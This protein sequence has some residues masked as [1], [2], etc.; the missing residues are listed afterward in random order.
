MLHVFCDGMTEAVVHHNCTDRLFDMDG[1]GEI[2]RN[3]AES[4]VVS[5][6]GLEHRF[7]IRAGRHF[8]DG[9][10]VT[11]E[12]CAQSLRRCDAL[13][14]AMVEAKGHD[15]L[16]ISL[17]RQN[18]T[19]LNLLAGSPILN[20]VGVGS[21]PYR[22]VE[23]AGDELLLTAHH[24]HPGVGPGSF[25]HIRLKRLPAHFGNY[26]NL[27]EAGNC[28]LV[29]S[30]ALSW[31]TRNRARGKW[32]AHVFATGCTHV[33]C[34]KLGYRHT[35]FVK[36]VLQEVFR[37]NRAL[38]GE[39]HLREAIS[40][41]PKG[42][43]L[44]EPIRVKRCHDGPA[45]LR[46]AVT[47]G[48]IYP[49]LRQRISELAAA[50]ELTLIWV[51]VDAAELMQYQFCDG[52][53]VACA[54]DARDAL[55]AAR[56]WFSGKAS[57]IGNL[58]SDLERML[59]RC[60]NVVRPSDRSAFLRQFYFNLFAHGPALPLFFSPNALVYSLDVDA[61]DLDFYAGNLDFVKLTRGALPVAGVDD[62]SIDFKMLAH[63]LRKPFTLVKAVVNVLKATDDPVRLQNLLESFVPEVERVTQ[64]VESM[65]KDMM[66]REGPTTPRLSLHSMRRIAHESIRVSL[67]PDSR[68]EVELAFQHEHLVEVDRDKI[69]RVMVNLLS[70]ATQ[71]MA[72]DGKI[73]IRT[74]E[75]ATSA[76][77]FVEIKVGNTNSYIAP[78]D[79]KHLF[80]PWFTK[81]KE[82]GT[83]LGLAIA[84]R[85]VQAHGGTIA[86]R[87]SKDA[88]TEF[89]F[90][91]PASTVYEVPVASVRRAVAVND[92]VKVAVVEDNIFLLELWRE[93]FGDEV[94]LFSS[95]EEFFTA[96]ENPEFLP[97]LNAAITDYYFDEKSSATGADIARFLHLKAFGGKVL[98]A[99]DSIGIEEDLTLFHG[100]HAKEPPTRQTLIELLNQ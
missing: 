60:E 29:G 78:D 17:R 5:P 28:V 72:G 67:P 15:G 13:S 71:A 33:L 2:A 44:Y 40:F 1:K 100:R 86:V 18:P 14:D 69:D 61:V 45:T 54:I 7:Q 12:Q 39:A 43:S 57:L 3:L 62:P 16:R 6:D 11:A 20:E 74:A 77:S 34:F 65:L 91:L 19:L 26:K 68:I 79:L 53:I 46:L 94:C 76:G 23:Q 22:V 95:P 81:G 24:D 35:D 59:A 51:E 49:E 63:D 41:Y 56:T 21:G 82:G 55:Q 75:L 31:V 38:A 8:H 58:P 70:N 88:G 93:Q 10:P 89:A 90:T 25:E 4:H 37:S 50:E 42:S 87:S 47:R 32:A 73:W 48:L 66:Q 97:S 96:A 98:L 92:R 85:F 27:L 52:R 84:Q 36:S 83:G 80:Q 64:S 99:S 9:S 30:G